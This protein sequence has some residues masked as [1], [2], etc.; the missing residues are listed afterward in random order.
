MAKRH[1]FLLA[2]I[3]L[4]PLAVW[5]Q[6]DDPILFTVEDTP[7]HQSEFVYIYSKTNGKKADFSRSS[8]QE[9]LD[10]YVKVKLKVQKAREMELDTIPQLMTELAGYRRQ[11]ADSYLIDKEVTDRLIE[12]GYERKQQD[13]NISLLNYLKVKIYNHK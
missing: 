1:F 12:E 2:A 3:F 9:Y 7:I 13:V 11:L 8:L 4:L 5:S 10:L 6:K